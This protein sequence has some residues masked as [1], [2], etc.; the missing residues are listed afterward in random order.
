MHSFGPVKPKAI[1]TW[2]AAAFGM[3]MADFFETAMLEFIA[4]KRGKP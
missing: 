2:P 4:K 1:A 3:S